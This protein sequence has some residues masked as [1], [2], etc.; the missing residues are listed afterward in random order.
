MVQVLTEHRIA[1]L[2][3]SDADLAVRFGRG[4]WPGADAQL[5]M[6]ERMSAVAAPKLARALRGRKPAAMLG[7]TLLHDSDTQH[8]RAWCRHAGIPYRPR[9]G[10]RRFDDYDLVLAAAEAGLGVAIARCPLASPAL[11]S[12]R[13]VRLDGPA[14]IGTNAHYLVTRHDET[15]HAVRRLGRELMALAAPDQTGGG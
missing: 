12:G 8:W 5:L 14:F 7:E 15:R 4:R 3:G 6:R 9:G 2:D 13:L 10:E 1:R 11:E